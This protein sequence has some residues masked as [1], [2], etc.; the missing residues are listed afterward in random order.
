MVIKSWFFFKMK[1]EL[2]EFGYQ[3]CGFKV[4]GETE[5]AYKLEVNA[6]RIDGEK[7]ITRIMW[8]PKSCVESKAN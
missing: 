4:V 2:R 7:E 5:K 3:M 1:S 6:Y 8:C